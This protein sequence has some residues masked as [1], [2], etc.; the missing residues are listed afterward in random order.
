MNIV[1]R[2]D[3][4]YIDKVGVAEDENLVIV[5]WKREWWYYA[6]GSVRV[7]HIERKS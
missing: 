5:P 6:I 2:Q 4:E 7:A 3:N 1:E